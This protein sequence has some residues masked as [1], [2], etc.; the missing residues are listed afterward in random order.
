MLWLPSSNLRTN[1]DMGQVLTKLR[2]VFLSR[3]ERLIDIYA[4]FPVH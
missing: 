4:M 1:S 2:S 3:K